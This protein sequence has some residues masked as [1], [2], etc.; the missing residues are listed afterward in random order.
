MEKLMHY[1]WQHRLWPRT[2]SRCVDGRTLQIIDPGRL[3][4]DAGPDFFNAKVKID[5]HL[6]VGDVEIHIK[7]SDWHRHNHDDDP[8]YDSVILHVVGRD[9]LPIRRRNG[10]IIP[11]MVMECSADLYNKVRGLV[12][13]ADRDLPCAASFK[14]IPRLHMTDWLESLAFERIYDK[15][16][17]IGRWLERLGGDW[18]S[19]AYVTLARALGFG[20]NSDPFERLAL[21]TPLMFIGKHCD[22]LLTVEALL[23]G[24]S[25]M[26]DLAQT[27]DEY[28]ARLKREYDFMRH[29]FG[30]K[31]LEN[32]G[33]KL[34]R[35]RSANF[36]TRRIAAL[37][38]LL[39]NN[40]RIM[41]DILDI[42]SADDAINLF[43]RPLTGYWTD[44]FTFSS[45]PTNAG[46]A[47]LGRMSAISLV[48][49]AV[50][51]LQ[52][53]YAMA[54]DD[55][56]MADRAIELLQSLPPEKNNIITMFSLNGLRAGSAFTS[57]ALIQL[58]RAYCETR[59]CLDCRIGH[60]M[61]S[62]GAANCRPDSA[63]RVSE[64]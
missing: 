6:W 59:K 56:E 5:G 14:S 40:T 8:A 57:Q 28:A 19:T 37:A 52:M 39:H 26:L 64:S 54:R 49:N 9:D 20:V 18:D 38:A 46:S 41:G 7:A 55:R 2:L 15:T 32:A 13:R 4:N 34:S 27:D 33:W 11:Q 61:L 30:L 60:L 29:K 43:T 36:P 21:A 48:I 35:T 53:A 58:R 25:G 24:Q 42:R 45:A 62:A 3:N 16:D 44:H 50:V 1:V 51:P 47:S 10:E 31:P 23:F 12:D 63:R 17:R 22:S